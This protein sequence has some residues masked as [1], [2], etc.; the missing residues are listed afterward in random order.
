MKILKK[1]NRKFPLSGCYSISLKTLDGG[2]LLFR[3][4]LAI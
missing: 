3:E 2:A 4:T 1:I